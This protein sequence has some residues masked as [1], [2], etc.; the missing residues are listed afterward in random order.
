[1]STECIAVKVHR[2]SGLLIGIFYLITNN[3]M[4]VREQATSQVYLYI[5]T[6][7]TYLKITIF[8]GR[9]T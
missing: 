8:N 2:P 3:T 9:L 1:M 7:P 6:I 5:S 4:E